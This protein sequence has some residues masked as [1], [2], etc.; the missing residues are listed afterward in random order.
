MMLS[1]DDRRYRAHFRPFIACTGGCSRLMHKFF[2][3]SSGIQP[4]A[5]HG[6]PQ[7]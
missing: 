3:P 1:H 7:P 6:Q 2:M 4:G 5:H